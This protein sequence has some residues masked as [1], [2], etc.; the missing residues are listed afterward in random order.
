MSRDDVKFV[1]HADKQVMP[2]LTPEV[3]RK[4][5]FDYSQLPGSF[6]KTL[7]SELSCYPLPQL[8]SQAKILFDSGTQ[9]LDISIPQAMM[10][11][12]ARG[13]VSPE[14][15]DSG[16]SAL[17]LGYTANAFSTRSGGEST[18]SAYVG[19]NAGLNVGAWYFR[20]DGSYNWQEKV[21]GDYQ[22]INNYVQR[23]IPMIKGR[24]LI[25]E[26]STNGQL[27]DTVPFKGAELVS[28][29]R[30]LPQS[31]RGYAPDIRGIARTN[32]R[33]TIRQNGR[34]IYETTVPPGAFVIDD[35]Y[36]TGY[37]GNLDVTV[38]EADGTSQNFLV[39]YASVTQ[40][41]RP[42][43]QRFGMVVGKLN[44]LSIDSD[45]GLFQATYQ[46][47]INNSI[48]GYGGV[49]TSSN[50]YA[51]QLGAA[52]GTPIGAFSA[53]VTQSR[54]HLESTEKRVNEGQSYQ[55]S[56]SKFIP[57][58]NSNLT[59]AT[60]RYSTE[61]YFDYLTAMRALD[62]EKHGQ[63]AKD[64]WRPRNRFN[65]TLNQGL[66]SGW[67]QVYLTGYSQDY[68]NHDGSDLQ[69]QLGYSNNYQNVSFSIS[70][71]RVRSMYGSMETNWL[72][73]LTM[74]LGNMMNSN[75][76]TLAAN[77]NHNSDG[78]TGEQVG[79]SGTAGK[80]SE[81]SYGVTGMN[82]NKGTGSSIAMNGAHR[83]QYTNITAA[84]GEGKDYKNASVGLSGT[85]IAWSDG[86]VLTPY[87]G[88]TFAVV[89][90]KGAS[91]AKVGGTRGFK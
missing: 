54:V 4:I 25:G 18:N 33:V 61:G 13:Y 22:S 56:Y 48:T 71:G 65:V 66:Y 2:C 30:M 88:D 37:G 74:P 45:P 55:L 12:V 10:Q 76:P 69:Y 49:Q 91:G 82:Y 29:D 14:L 47:G 90:A 72:F 40:L 31:Q 35:L 43:A 6:T 46:R 15:W 64:I 81:Y 24:I 57:E 38:A 86:V 42:G 7:H 17:M 52:V 8:I 75:I 23:D 77:L 53:D 20:H 58:S 78:R 16:L 73:S 28:D 85:A 26:T 3:L 83:S 70:A 84:Y 80:D 21:G 63:T 50:Y 51:L 87:T 62:A 34:V 89:E 19:L 1:E 39:P 11:K 44:D 68:W 60:Y 9:R 41:L 36:P 79:V 27:F 67:G 5:N 32:A 59:I